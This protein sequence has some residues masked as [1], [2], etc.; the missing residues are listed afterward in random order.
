MSIRSRLLAHFLLLSTLGIVALGVYHWRSFHAYY[1]QTETADLAARNVALRDAVA[2]ALADNND[3]RVEQIVAVNG[4]QPGITVRVIAPDGRI[5]STSTD[6]EDADLIDWRGV[7]GVQNAL[8]GRPSSG[9]AQGV[10]ARGDRLY[11]ARPIRRQGK[12]LGVVRISLTLDR[13]EQELRSDLSATV[14]TVVL[15]LMVC[16]VVSIA[17]ARSFADPIQLMRNFAVRVGGGHFGERLQ[18]KRRDELA[19]LAAELNRMSEQLES[20]ETERRTFLANVAH[21]LRTPVTNAEVALHALETGGETS[22]EVR[23]RFAR[24]A[25]AEIGRLHHLVQDL[26]DLGRLEAGVDSFD[27]QIV[28]LSR[29]LDDTL[30]GVA[31]RLEQRGMTVSVDLPN[32]F[33]KVDPARITQVFMNLFENALKYAGSDTTLYLTGEV[34]G[35]VVAVRLE[36]EGPGID[37]KDL[38]HVFQRF[39]TGD[40]SRAGAGTGLGL[41]IAWRIVEAHGGSIEVESPPGRGAAFIVELPMA[42]SPDPPGTEP[43]PQAERLTGSAGLPLPAA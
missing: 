33:V 29:L 19:Q 3:E 40:R 34:K 24:A 37:A 13:F 9:V 35:K 22:P 26:L 15:G 18:I 7:P 32:A 28:N 1:I 8:L 4:R 5:I 6:A 20:I 43:S 39:F 36:D 12:L 42:R 41:A 2:E 10:F 17:L 14:L 31:R 30:E 25:S 21:E 16:G 11:D 27:Y 38:P 23:E